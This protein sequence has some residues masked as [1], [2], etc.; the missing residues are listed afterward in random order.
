MK[1]D[2]HHFS[3]LREV[4]SLD[5]SIKGHL[6]IIESE[7]ARIAHL[8][9]LFDRRETEFNEAQE[10]LNS[11]RTELK[12]LEREC[13]DWEEK[14]TKAKSQE[15]SAKNEKQV[16][17]LR[18]ESE[19]SDLEVSRLQDLQLELLE[20]LE[21]LE[22]T[23]EEFKKFK[24]G[25]EITKAK[26]QGEVDQIIEKETIEINRYRERIKS[27]LEELPSNLKDTFQHVRKMHRF[28]QPLVRVI[29][30]GCE[31]CKFTLDSSSCDQV[32]T[33][34]VIQTCNSCHRLFIPFDS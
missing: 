9:S 31:K 25:F 21:T 14:V 18:N 20:E 2:K 29:N 16:E 23:I 30:K 26:I 27:L 12:S 10:L 6:D 7:N 3:S 19:T 15:G 22:E 13:H 8:N 4:Q 11:K 24:S 32:E 17:A 34:K 1:L 33:L 28:K 5:N